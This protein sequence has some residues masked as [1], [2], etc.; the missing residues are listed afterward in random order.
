VTIANFVRLGIA[1][2]SG[3]QGLEGQEY[4]IVWKMKSL[5]VLNK[6]WVWIERK[7]KNGGGH[8]LYNVSIKLLGHH[9]VERFLS[10]HEEIKAPLYTPQVIWVIFPI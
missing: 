7:L 8:V 3:G 10:K 9:G 5:E 1:T 4:K 6:M 2:S